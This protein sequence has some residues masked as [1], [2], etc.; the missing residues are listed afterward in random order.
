MIPN[1]RRPPATFLCAPLLLLCGCGYIGEPLPPLMN[2]PGRGENLVAVER[3]ASIIVH[4]TLPALTTEGVVIKQPMRLDL[5]VAPKPAGSYKIETWAAGAKAIGGAVTTNGIAE[6]RFPAAEWI[7]KQVLIAIK[8]VGANGRDAGWSTPVELAVVAPPEEPRDL[9]AEVLPQG[10]RLTWHAAGNAFA[11]LRRG[12]DEAGFAEVGRSTKP[13][14]VDATIEF[15]K[16]Y[17]YLVQA[18]AKAGSAEAQSGLSNEV[19]ITPL[20][21]FPPSAPVGLAAVP[22]TAS[23]EL[24]WERNAEPNVIGYYVYRALG[25]APFERLGEMQKL[26]AYSDH[27]IAAGKTYRYAVSAVK[28]NNVESPRSQP[29]EVNLP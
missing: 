27:Q 13:E 4:V 9:N 19:D 22:S 15:G 3:G 25:A 8:I 20:D 23:V 26:P 7:G 29:V 5:R 12:P 28:S 14:Y 16:K 1:P 24:V 10:V 17:S 18:V 21:T 6:Y 2:V 11:I